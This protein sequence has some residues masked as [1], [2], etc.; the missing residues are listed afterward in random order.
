MSVSIH[1]PWEGCDRGGAE[2]FSHRE[3]FNSRTLGR[4][5]LRIKKTPTGSTEFQFTHP[6]KG[7]TR[8][9]PHID[10]EV[11]VSIHAPWEGCDSFGVGCSLTAIP[12]F[13]SR[14]L[15]RVRHNSNNSTS[16]GTAVSIHAPWE[17]CDDQ[18]I[19]Y[20][21]SSES[22]NSRTLGRVRPLEVQLMQA[23]V[24]FQFT[25]PGKGATH[26]G[27]TSSQYTYVSIHAPWEGC[28]YTLPRMTSLAVLFQF[29][30]PGKGATMP[31][32]SVTALVL[33]QFTHP[34][35]GAT[36]PTAEPAP[37]TYVSIHAPWEGCDAAALADFWPK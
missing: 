16:D 32:Y 26:F 34:G 13:N 9:Q 18:G 17:G 1:A 24:E 2:T 29:T 8:T 36:A 7:A 33:F 3:S 5:R 12:S 23:N 4:V 30:H 14:T 20:I 21:P 35:K 31:R 6:G 28:D 37:T 27:N 10:I 11:R 15:G 22:F 19:Y 25:H